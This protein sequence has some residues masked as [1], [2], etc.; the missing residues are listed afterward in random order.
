HKSPSAHALDVNG[1]AAFSGS[2]NIGTETIKSGLTVTGDI[3]SDNI[4]S[5]RGSISQL[6]VGGPASFS[7]NVGIGTDK[8]QYPLDVAS[9]TNKTGIVDYAYSLRDGYGNDSQKEYVKA[10]LR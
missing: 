9:T 10:N 3:I 1:S 8:P 2:L 6:A 5:G 4:I 7:S